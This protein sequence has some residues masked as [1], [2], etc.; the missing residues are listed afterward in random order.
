LPDT[1][2]NR[3]V[4]ELFKFFISMTKQFNL[5]H[6]VCLT[7]DSYY[8]E[9][10]YNETK[11]SNTSKFYLIDH[12]NKKDIFYWLEEKE[13]IEHKIVKDIWENL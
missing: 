5:C 12:L 6:I 10:L 9:E 3:V 8:M 2:D 11:L 4:E 7:S 1:P 13:K